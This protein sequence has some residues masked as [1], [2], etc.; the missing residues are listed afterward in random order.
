[1]R[2]DQNLLTEADI[3]KAIK[4]ELRVF[5]RL[6][7]LD[8]PDS[9]SLLQNR[10]PTAK[11]SRG[12]RDKNNGRRP[13]RH[14]GIHRLAEKHEILLPLDKIEAQDDCRHRPA[15][16]RSLLR[17]VW[18]RPPYA[19]TPLDGIKAKV[20]PNVTVELCDE[21]RRWRRP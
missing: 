3:D 8:P 18:V 21:Q 6:G 12:P 16:E 11:P 4:G 15:R 13:A 5:V 7:L 10:S 14:A 9:E 20:G 17:L 2:A 1:M 19:V